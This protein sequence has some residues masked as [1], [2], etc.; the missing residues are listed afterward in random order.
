MLNF[1]RLKEKNYNCLLLGL[2]PSCSMVVGCQYF[3]LIIIPPSFT[4][5]MEEVSISKRFNYQQTQ[6]VTALRTMVSFSN[7]IENYK[8]LIKNHA[9]I[10]IVFNYSMVQS[11]S[12][13]ANW[14]AASQEIPRILWKPK[15]HYRTHKRSLVIVLNNIIF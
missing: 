15:V 6:D 12:W 11:P 14:F 2:V 10:V 7:I 1:R 4:L 13:E 5:K 3:R 8:C 9:R